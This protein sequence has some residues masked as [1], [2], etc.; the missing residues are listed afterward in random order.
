MF[1]LIP[2]RKKEKTGVLG[3][4]DVHPL[5]RLRSEFEALF[6]RF[7]GAWPAPFA[8]DGG[9][10][11]G[12]DVRDEGKEYVVRAEA[13]GIEPGDF[14]VQVTGNHLV[15]KAE[16]K[17]EAKGGAGDNYSFERR[18]FRRQVVLPGGADPDKVEA[19]YRNGVLEIHLAKHP[20]AQGKRIE[21]KAP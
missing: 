5:S 17:H 4:A 3:A 16:R 18:S 6:D 14:D 20:E 8:N 19:R 2:W 12:L 21:V 10:A 9:L 13:P 7:L 15:L 1:N 11:W